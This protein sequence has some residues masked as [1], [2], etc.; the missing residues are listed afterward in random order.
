MKPILLLLKSMVQGY[1]RKDGV[2]VKPHSD[3]RTK[4]AKL[5]DHQLVL[6]PAPAKKPL[7]PNP[8]K[9]LDPVKSTGDL[10]EDHKPATAAPSNE[11]DQDRSYREWAENWGEVMGADLAKVSDKNLA[12]AYGFGSHVVTMEHA[13]AQAGKPWNENLVNSIKVELD[14][15]RSEEKRRAN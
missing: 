5:N 2:V 15:I 9:G 13:K 7:P 14:A 12:R 11:S 4:R 10:F 8:F 3:T 6:F 1:T